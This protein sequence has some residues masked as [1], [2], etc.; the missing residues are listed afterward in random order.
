MANDESNLDRMVLET[1]SKMA[2]EDINNDELERYKLDERKRQYDRMSEL[3]LK[4]RERELYEESPRQ[5][6][7][8][9]YIELL[10]LGFKQKRRIRKEL[11]AWIIAIATVATACGVWMQVSDQ[12]D[13][14][15]VVAPKA[16]SKPLDPPN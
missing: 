8:Q 5:D 9:L 10:L 13:E 4:K 3:D 12:T 6:D 11:P 7:D 1:H 14:T 16:Q 15:F 2:Q